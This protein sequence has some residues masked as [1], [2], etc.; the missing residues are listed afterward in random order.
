MRWWSVILLAALVALP[1][2]AAAD[3]YDWSQSANWKG[4]GWYQISDWGESGFSLE[5]GPYPGKEECNAALPE[6][7]PLPADYVRSEWEED[8]FCAF[9]DASGHEQ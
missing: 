7:Y 2:A 5:K 1:A 8:Y 4:E 6:G 9:I 3:A